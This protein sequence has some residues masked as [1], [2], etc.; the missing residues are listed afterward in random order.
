MCSAVPPPSPAKVPLLLRV[1]MVTTTDRPGRSKGTIAPS[2]G[3]AMRTGT[4]C[5]ILVKFPVA[6]SGG[7]RLNSAPLPGAKLSTQPLSG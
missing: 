4:R 7:S 2:F 1:S 6:F 3:K 5:T